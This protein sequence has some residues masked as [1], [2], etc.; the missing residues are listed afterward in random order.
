MIAT[1]HITQT[2]RHC[3]AA[4]VLAEGHTVADGHGSSL[5]FVLRKAAQIK[6]I[7]AMHVWYHHICAG[8]KTVNYIRDWA[9][10]LAQD[11]VDLERAIAAE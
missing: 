8:T 2:D 7:S 1:L 10:L 3:Y 4:Q 11:L 5:A 9:E 6:G